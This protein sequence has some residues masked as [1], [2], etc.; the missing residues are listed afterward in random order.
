VQATL[1]EST[2][3]PGRIPVDDVRRR[4]FAWKV[5]EGAVTSTGMNQ[6]GVFTVTDTDRKAIMRPPGALGD[7]DQGAILGVFKGGYQPHDY[8][9]WLLDDVAL[10]LD[11]DLG[12]YSAGL[13]RGGAQAWVQVSIP[14]AITT[15]EGVTFRPNLLA[16]TSFDGS[17]ATTYKRTVTN[18]VCDN[19]MGSALKEDG[20][21]FKVKHSRYSYRR[22]AEARAALEIVHQVSESFAA[23]I[24]ELCAVTITP[25]AWARFLDDLAPTGE[26]TGR[27]LTLAETKRDELTRLWNHDQRVSPWKGTAW[28]AVQAVNTYAHHCQ[29]VRGSDRAER[30]MQQ[31]V[32]G[33]WDSL[34]ADT[35][36]RILAAV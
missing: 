4:L 27:S 9:R 32:T 16:V 29:T 13:L 35:H 2:V 30:N 5:A 6:E 11:D 18:T 36:A 1:D 31:A 34:D 33:G 20:A 21:T 17:L 19:T 24:A 25:D 7:D 8:E 10:I 28:G 22:L 3:Y 12:I 14:D 15:P 23:K 26:K